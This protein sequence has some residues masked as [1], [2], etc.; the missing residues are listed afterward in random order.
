M[1]PL[2]LQIVSR[3]L[4]R[5]SFFFFIFNDANGRYDLEKKGDATL[6]SKVVDGEINEEACQFNV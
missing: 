2:R 3:A 5:A 1:Q 4:K 6:M